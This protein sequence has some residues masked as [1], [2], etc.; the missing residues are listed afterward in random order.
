MF[1]DTVYCFQTISTELSHAI[2]ERTL[3]FILLVIIGQM[4]LFLPQGMPSLKGKNTEFS[5]PL[6]SPHVA[7]TSLFTSCC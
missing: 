6:N 2:V 4:H 3:F 5:V 1:S 7:F